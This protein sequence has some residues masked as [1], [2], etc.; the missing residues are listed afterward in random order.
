MCTEHETFGAIDCSALAIGLL[1]CAQC[2][3]PARVF[4]ASFC[5]SAAPPALPNVSSYSVSSSPPRTFFFLFVHQKADRLAGENVHRV[6]HATLSLAERFATSAPIKKELDNLRQ[7]AGGD[8]LLEAAAASIPQDAAVKGIP[9]PLQLKQRCVAA[10]WHAP[11]ARMF[12]LARWLHRVVSA[13]GRVY[14][15]R[16]VDVMESRDG[17]VLTWHQAGAE[18][19]AIGSV[20]LVSQP[21]RGGA[22]SFSGWTAV[23]GVVVRRKRKAKMPRLPT[24][25]PIPPVARRCVERTHHTRRQQLERRLVSPVPPD[26]RLRFCTCPRLCPICFGHFL[27]SAW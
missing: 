11:L 20:G 21:E 8:P 5:C 22:L 17:R 24:Y 9:T 19:R 4:S 14:L 6:T 12:S 16:G 23:S 7:L 10:P 26:D 27:G 1:P 18:S 3:A 13:V 2:T 25:S 15:G